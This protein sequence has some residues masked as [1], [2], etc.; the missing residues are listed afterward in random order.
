MSPN[1]FYLVFLAQVLLL[2]VVLPRRQVAQM[3]N[4]MQKY[5]PAEFPRLYPQAEA[6]YQASWQKFLRLNTVFAGIG[7]ALLGWMMFVAPETEW[8]QQ[9][10]TG[11]YLLQFV[12]W[13]ALDCS[14]LRE[15]RLMRLLNKDSTRSA[16]LKRRRLFDAVAP[17]LVYAAIGMFAIMCLFMV[18]MTQFNYDWFGGFA[19]IVI[20]AIVN[21][22]GLFIT[23]RM[24]HGKRIDPHE[25]EADRLVRAGNTIRI[26]LLTSI[27]LSLYAIL[28]VSLKAAGLEAWQPLAL[29][30]YL[31]ILVLFTLRHYSFERQDYEVY[32]GVVE[33]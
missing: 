4:M 5:P 16:G 28:T 20:L 17:A 15:Y 18:W 1:F 13:L 26:L 30:V 11:F 33:G 9:I 14:A 24:L 22:V 31:Q 32:R 2:S 6:H 27:A 25:S 10:V 23:W 7:L 12:P 21:V 19:N 3:E 8:K 29:S